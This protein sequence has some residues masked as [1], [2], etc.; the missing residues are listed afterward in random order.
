MLWSSCSSPLAMKLFLD[1]ANLKEIET[2][3]SWGILDGVTTNPTLL[4]LEGKVDVEKH[5]KAICKQAVGPVSMEVIATDAKGMVEEGKKYAK[6]AEN[7][8]VKVPMTA[9]GLKAVIELRHFG[10]P[11][12]VTLIFS[13]NQ[14]LLAAK[15]GARFVSPFIGRLDE[16]GEDGLSLVNEIVQIFDNYG[17][18]TEV[19][20]ASVRNPRQVTEVARMGADVATLPFAVFEK[21]LHHPMTDLGVE[22]FLK[23][24][25]STQK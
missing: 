11:T 14:A 13:A 1:T 24:W 7:I 23:D 12:N 18:E 10:V 5:L 21:M 6:W 8:V 2:V 9:E 25:K 20:V 16:N 15:A 3:S 4:S 19:L 17:F 22:R